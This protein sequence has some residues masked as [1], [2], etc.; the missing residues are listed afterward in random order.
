MASFYSV[1]WIGLIIDP[2]WVDVFLLAER[3]T[4]KLLCKALCIS[5][6]IHAGNKKRRLISMSLRR[7]KQFSNVPA[8]SWIQ[9]FAAKITRAKIKAQGKPAKKAVC[10]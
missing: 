4:E 10:C 8:F 7:Y 9:F 5:L 1:S 6:N 2:V 3:K